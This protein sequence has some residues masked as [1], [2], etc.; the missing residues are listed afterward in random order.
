M[1]LFT[2]FWTA[3]CVASMQAPNGDGK[4]EVKT[5]KTACTKV[6]CHLKQK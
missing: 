2:Q 6:K 1:K 5:V 4:L 3:K